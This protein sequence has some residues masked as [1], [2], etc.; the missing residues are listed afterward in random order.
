[1]EVYN[2]VEIS[3]KI[4]NLDTGMCCF[5]ETKKGIFKLKIGVVATDI[6][7]GFHAVDCC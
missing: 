4:H 5:V 1:M 6:Y 7:L 2:P 3:S